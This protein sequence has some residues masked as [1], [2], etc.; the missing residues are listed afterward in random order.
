[1]SFPVPN[2][3]D[4]PEVTYDNGDVVTYPPA[5]C[6]DEPALE[7]VITEVNGIRT[8]ADG[9]VYPSAGDAVRG[10]VS[11][12]KEDLKDSVGFEYT[13]SDGYIAGDGSITPAGAV[14]KEKYTSLIP[15]FNGMKIYFSLKQSQTRGNWC[16]Y[17]LYDKDE[18]FISRAVPISNVWE[19]VV[20]YDVDIDNSA[21]KYISFTW[22]S[23]GDGIE[24][25]RIADIPN[26]FN[27]L[28]DKMISGSYVKAINHRGSYV[29]AINHRGYNA[30]A[31]ENTLPAYK[32]SAQHDFKYVETDVRFT[33]D[34]V[35]VCLHDATINRTARNNN[36]SE[37]SSAINIHDITYEQALT[38]DFGIYKGSSYTGTRIPT[39][40]Q[41]LLLCRNLG[42]HLYIELKYDASYTEEQIKSLV[43][44]VDRYAMSKNVSWIS[45]YF[46]Y[47]E[48]VFQKKSDARLGFI[49]EQIQD[50]QIRNML[51]VKSESNEIFID[52]TAVN[53]QTDI[54]KC[55]NNGIGFEVWT[56]DDVNTLISLNPYVSGVTSNNLNASKV[57]YQESI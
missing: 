17:G 39:F 18:N 45:S 26:T 31:P 6:V 4:M 28:Y 40:E 36:G 14:T 23:Y 19:S 29:K 34:G 10:Q 21:V 32:M 48:Y 51:T 43:D 33:S 8:G 44:I 22:R 53:T 56:V 15:V 41:L 7:N 13:K 2:K 9:T 55:I 57:L 16:A 42:L 52:G 46:Y 54:D 27:D 25:I 24:S 30:V 3:Y 12:L 35:P 1:M 38:Y 47:L 11:S 37:I 5:L 20:S 49:A 50:Y